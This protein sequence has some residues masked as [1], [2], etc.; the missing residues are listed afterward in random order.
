MF[1]TLRFALPLLVLPL[2]VRTAMSQPPDAP[3]TIKK[4][5]TQPVFRAPVPIPDPA[6][7]TLTALQTLIGGPTFVTFAAQDVPLTDV[8]KALFE[9]GK[10]SQSAGRFFIE[11]QKK[12]SVD[13]DKTPFW[14]AAGD[15]EKQSG[16]QWNTRFG[17]GLSLQQLP[18]EFA[19]GMGGLPGLETPLVTLIAN[20]I[21]RT[22]T[23]TAALV[24]PMAPAA[25]PPAQTERTQMTLSAYFDPKIG[26]QSAVL[27]AVKFQKEGET[28][29]IAAAENQFGYDFGRGSSLITQLNL[30]IPQEIKPGAKLS[31]ISGTLHSVVITKTE[32]L[33]VPDVIA[34]PKVSKTIGTGEYALQSATVEGDELTIR[35]SAIQ[36]KVEGQ[37][38]MI[39]Y[40][41]NVFQNL[42]VRD[43]QGNAL[44][45]GSSSGSIGP[46]ATM[47]I[48]FRLKNP[49]G[50]AAVGPF[51]LEWPITTETKSLDLPF[52]LRDVVVP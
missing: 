29:L 20:S 22:T 17:D 3:S 27:R 41:N 43:A 28:A 49:K 19:G 48:R 33:S 42:S 31:R 44:Q 35:L 8:T 7:I 30:S 39:F 23:R 32:S 1:R 18:K 13:W 24:D 25:A 36:G 5:A 10:I 9:A 50:E 38:Q 4:P 21:A 51:S 14:S 46:K 37:D 11:N 34:T 2:L 16:A 47:E 45:R 26:V 40:R 52:E 15:I 12:I 6:P